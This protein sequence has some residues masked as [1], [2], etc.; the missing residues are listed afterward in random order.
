MMDQKIYFVTKGQVFLGCVGDNFVCALDDSK[1]AHL[2]VLEGA[3]E[4]LQL[5]KADLL[6]YNSVAPAI[7]GCEGVFHVASPVPS[8][9]SSN[10]EAS[11]ST[12]YVSYFFSSF[13]HIS[14]G[15][16]LNEVVNGWYI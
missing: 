9:R 11:S 8:G 2:K 10:P 7:A 15:Q 1:N 4:R 14:R 5:F 3:G 6:D 13:E 12:T 16:L